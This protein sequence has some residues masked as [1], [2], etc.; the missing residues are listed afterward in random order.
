MGDLH[1]YLTDKDR[2]LELQVDASQLNGFVVEAL[3]QRYPH[4]RFVLTVREPRAWLDSFYD[5]H[6]SQ[7][8]VKG[9]WKRLIEHRWSQY[10]AHGPEDRLLED[11]GFP[12]VAGRLQDWATRIDSVTSAVPPD[13]LL[14]VRTD[15]LTSSINVL[16][17]FS[18]VP[19]SML[20]PEGAHSFAAQERHGLLDKI[21][22]EY[23]SAQIERFCQ[24]QLTQLFGDV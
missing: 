21:A 6:L 11:Y 19:E 14:I 12:S 23:V 13:R 20:D 22:P 4:G 7:G 10:P 24:P 16:A 5:H 1:N 3:V 8:Q 18:G 2:R 17:D 9:G 15:L